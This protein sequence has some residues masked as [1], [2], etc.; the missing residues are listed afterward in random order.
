MRIRCSASPPG[1]APLELLG[2]GLGVVEA[3]DAGAA[4]G[5]GGEVGAECDV[6][7]AIGS[8]RR[9]QSASILIIGIRSRP[10]FTLFALLLQCLQFPLDESLE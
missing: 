2:A 4:G 6:A 8:V 7:A 9:V 5:G 3:A 10:T 1:D